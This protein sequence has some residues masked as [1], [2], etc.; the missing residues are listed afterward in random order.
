[1]GNSQIAD[2]TAGNSVLENIVNTPVG[3]PSETFQSAD[4]NQ[5]QSQIQNQTAPGQFEASN[6]SGESG[7]NSF[8]GAAYGSQTAGGN[9]TGVA[10]EQSTGQVMNTGTSSF[11]TG[12]TQSYLQAATADQNQNAAPQKQVVA[13]GI[14]NTPLYEDENGNLVDANNTTYVYDQNGNAV[15]AASYQ[16]GSQGIDQQALANLPTTNSSGLSLAD[17]YGVP[18]STLPTAATLQSG[19][20]A[21][22]ASGDPLYTNPGGQVVDAQG[23][24]YTYNNQNQYVSTEPQVADEQTTVSGWDAGSSSGVGYTGSTVG[25]A[26][27]PNPNGATT[28]F[29]QGSNWNNVVQALTG[30]DGIGATVSADGQTIVYPSGATYSYSEFMAGQ[31]PPSEVAGAASSPSA[32]LPAGQSYTYPQPAATASG[33]S[34]TK[35][36]EVTGIENIDNGSTSQAPGGNQATANY[37]WNAGSSSGVAFTGTTTAQQQNFGEVA[38]PNGATTG[39]GQ[40]SNWNNVVQAVT[41]SDGI[42]ATVSADGKTITLP[43]G[44]IY[45]YND[46]MAGQ[47]L[48]DSGNVATA[49]FEYVN[50]VAS[51]TPTELS[52]QEQTQAS[53]ASPA[54]ETT[55]GLT[56][57]QLQNL[58]AQQINPTQFYQPLAEPTEPASVTLEQL[59]NLPAQPVNLT[60]YSQKGFADVPTPDQAPADSQAQPATPGFATATKPFDPSTLSSAPMSPAQINLPEAPAVNPVLVTPPAP[61]L[62]LEQLLSATPTVN[63]PSAGAN[64]TPAGQ[65]PSGV[66]QIISSNNPQATASPI[67]QTLNIPTSYITVQD[68]NGNDTGYALGTDGKYYKNVDGNYT[69]VSQQ[70]LE[71][72]LSVSVG[73][74]SQAQTQGQSIKDK[75]TSGLGSVGSAIGLTKGDQDKQVSSV[76]S[77][78]NKNGIKATV[79]DDGTIDIVTDK[80]TGQSMTL[81]PSELLSGYLSVNKG[82]GLTST[83]T[84]GLFFVNPLA[85]LAAKGATGALQGAQ[86]QT[87]NAA[88]TVVINDS[89]SKN[90]II[91]YGDQL[92]MVNGLTGQTQVISKNDFG[93]AL[94][95]I[96][97]GNLADP[98]SSLGMPNSVGNNADNSMVGT[99]TNFFKGMLGSNTK[100]NPTWQILQQWAMTPTSS[101]QNP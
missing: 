92:I 72:A 56:M 31:Q 95:L 45:S 37:G 9:A 10:Y 2:P 6:D 40:G 15:P 94:Y 74:S 12:Q 27:V 28:G 96:N 5:P 54:A 47:Q 34:E 3:G 65:L 52:G 50:P 58:P 98:L 48:P 60:S 75:I 83:L 88:N 7:T 13:Y 19:P 84:T 36:F 99:A 23:N 63:P 25:V 16:V 32:I 79:N 18:Q 76:V 33:S 101:Q 4:Q 91:L 49:P 20:S 43:N 38:N 39:F 78:L 44:N 55:A 26:D 35:P 86:N 8:T 90:A 14:N 87:V 64:Q 73:D 85:G 62:T 59:Q 46:F 97:N 17:Q 21:F 22:S 71:A 67:A 68:G 41:G 24:V 1:V 93:T 57:Q 70:D 30:S 77:Q 69:Q 61:T 51:A 66:Q 82:G 89:Q 11:G 81:S 29:G 53:S 80:A 42:G 100:T